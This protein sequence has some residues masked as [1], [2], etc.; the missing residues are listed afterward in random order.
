MALDPHGAKPVVY[1]GSPSS[2]AAYRI[3]RVTDLGAEL[4]PE[5]VKVGSSGKLRGLPYPQGTD[6]EGN[7]FFLDQTRPMP[8]GG[9][10]Q[11]W[12]VRAKSGELRRWNN[13]S[14]YRGAWGKDGYF[15][16]ANWYTGKAITRVDRTGKVVAFSATGEKSVAYNGNRFSFVRANLH[17]LASGDIW[18]LYKLEKG[19][20]LVS[21]IGPDGKIRRKEVVR[22]L[23]GAACVRVDSRGNIYVADGLKRDGQPYPPEIAEFAGRLRAKGT[24]ARG[25]HGEA[26]EDAY[27]EGYGGLLKFGPGGGEISRANSAADGATLLTAYPHKLK[28]AAK[29]LKAIYGRISPMSPPRYD[30]PYSACWCLHAMFDVD[31]YDR[32]VVPDALQ[33]RVRVLDAN[34]NEILSFGGYDQ[35]TAKGGKANAPGPE[36]PFEFPSYVNAGGDHVYVTDSASCARRVV[37]VKLRYACEETCRTD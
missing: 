5:V 36:I 35:A 27:G 21:A 18:A 32:L 8:H 16:R 15:Y 19:H 10:I 2:F 24:T 7:F 29:G 25:Y 26:V 33:F 20:M 22:G 30:Y 9:V 37:R 11:G 28:F 34:F 3:L 14:T 4:K 6:G 1:L 23:Q 13:R 31:A 12:E 17:P